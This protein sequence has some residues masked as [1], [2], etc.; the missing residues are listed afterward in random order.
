MTAQLQELGVNVANVTERVHLAINL[1]QSFAH[2]Y[3]FDKHSYID[4]DAMRDIVCRTI[5]TLFE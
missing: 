4:Y 3:V 1:V 5:V 2:E